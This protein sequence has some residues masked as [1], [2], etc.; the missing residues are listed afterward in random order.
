M[1]NTNEL[2]H[3][4]FEELC[5]LAALGQIS[6]GEYELLQ[7]HLQTCS[8]CQNCLADFNEILHEHLPLL[9]AQEEIYSGSGRVT[10][11]DA[12][13]KHRFVQRAAAEGIRFSDEFAGK[14]GG[15][16][17]GLSGCTGSGAAPGVSVLTGAIAGVS[18]GAWTTAGAAS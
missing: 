14:A 13:Y 2:S 1:L 5:S 6:A 12:S 7:T 10:F 9:D 18:L 17:P 8:T 11:H 3:E 16:T 4:Y 15:A